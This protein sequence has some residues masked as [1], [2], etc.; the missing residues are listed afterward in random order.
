MNQVINKKHIK[1]QSVKKSLGE[2]YL[3][4]EI[5][6]GISYSFTSDT[7]YGLQGASGVGKST[8]MHLIAGIDAPS[9]GEVLF[10]GNHHD[11]GMVFQNPYLINELTVLENVI[12][13]ARLL[14]VGEPE[15]HDQACKLLHE[16][17]LSDKKNSFPGEL[18]G[19]QQQ[20]V[21]LARA[22]LTRPQFLLAD[23]PTG[24]LDKETSQAIINMIVSY[25]R[26]YGMGVI[27]SSHDPDVLSAMDICL[28]LENGQLV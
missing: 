15:L 21:A 28:K 8:L 4:R 3:K 2:G 18:S 13:K 27:M 10:D 1:L 6:K 12:L 19:G 22:L 7:L 9:S 24:N 17:Q 23:E 14:G 26:Q 16:V 25:H 5:L 11:L 20:R